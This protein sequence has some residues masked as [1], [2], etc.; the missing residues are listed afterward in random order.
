MDVGSAQGSVKDSAEPG[1]E[2]DTTFL[3]QTRKI[4]FMVASEMSVASR[5]RL[6]G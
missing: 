6:A 5:Q 3:N 4:F 1:G 2:E